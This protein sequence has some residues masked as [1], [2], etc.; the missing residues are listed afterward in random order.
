MRI[1]PVILEQLGGLGIETYAPTPDLAALLARALAPTP[2][3]NLTPRSDTEVGDLLAAGWDE[4]LDA[5]LAQEQQAQAQV[6]QLVATLSL[7]TGLRSLQPKRDTRTGQTI[8][9]V[10]TAEARKV[11]ADW[12][13]VAKG[14][15]QY[16][17]DQLTQLSEMLIEAET[18]RVDVEQAAW[19]RLWEHV[20]AQGP[21]LIQL[22]RD[23]AQ[24]DVLTTLAHVAVREQWTRPT[25][26]PDRVLSIVG[27]RHPV[28]CRTVEPSW[29][30]M[31]R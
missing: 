13:R 18:Q 11:P 26:V 10:S 22:A 21:R 2:R 25:I 15:E 9:T 4:E 28:V 3:A 14:K 6:E 27:G 31:R 8:L 29:M 30:G 12:S 7:M 23:L 17:T 24:V 1:W 19:R 20:A 5:L 16:T